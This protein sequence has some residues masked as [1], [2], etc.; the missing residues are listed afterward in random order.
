MSVVLLLIGLILIAWV[1]MSWLPRL[2]EP[3]LRGIAARMDVA[4]SPLGRA[5]ERVLGV[6][7]AELPLMIILAIVLIVATWGAF[8]ILEDVVTGDPIIALDRRI[9]DSLQI[10]RTPLLDRVMIAITTLGDQAIVIPVGLA[11]LAACLATRRWRASLFILAAISGA[12]LF[13]GGLKTIIQRPR[14]VAVYDGIAQYSFPSGHATMSVT[15]YGFLAMLLIHA[16]PLAFRRLVA[17]AVTAIILLIAVSRLYLGAHWFSDVAA[18]L[19]FGAAW[20]ALLSILY[21]R[22]SPPPLAAPLFTSLILV[23]LVSAW[24]WHNARDGAAEAHRYE[25]PIA[26]TPLSPPLAVQRR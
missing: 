17:F 16:S 25:R 12:A 4:G 8:A 20:V 15:L 19:A 7:T 18:G 6:S 14:P 23:V 5:A 10:L 9:Y 2:I 21:F 13:V 22:S 1:A 24:G 26:L 3:H 11:A